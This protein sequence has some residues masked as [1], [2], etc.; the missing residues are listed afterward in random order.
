MSED[1]QG[2]PLD[3]LNVTHEQ[4]RP[5]QRYYA[6]LQLGVLDST[7]VEGLLAGI[8][9]ARRGCFQVQGAGEVVDLLLAV[10]LQSGVK[11]RCL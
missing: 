9:L 1:V 8:K 10:G 3:A 2:R 6:A 7:K 11:C 5:A 4:G